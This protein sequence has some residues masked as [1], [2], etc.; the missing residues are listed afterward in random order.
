MIA[1]RSGGCICLL[2]LRTIQ[3]ALSA[4][5]RDAVGQLT[6]AAC[7]LQASE[8]AVVWALTNLDGKGKRLRQ[9]LRAECLRST[10]DFEVTVVQLWQTVFAHFFR[11]ASLIKSSPLALKPNS[12]C[13]FACRSPL[14]SD[15]HR[16]GAHQHPRSPSCGV[17]C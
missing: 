16:A 14:P 4:T 13:F 15:P 2:R 11:A 1:Y 10:H 7:L 8:R 5:E 17:S 9:R 6:E 12:M 3:S